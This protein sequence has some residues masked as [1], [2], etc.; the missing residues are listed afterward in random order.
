[1][2][3]VTDSPQET[4]QKEV[5]AYDPKCWIT[6]CGYGADT[7]IGWT[8]GML[9]TGLYGSL[10]CSDS[11]RSL[12]ISDQILRIRTFLADQY[13]FLT[14]QNDRK[15]STVQERLKWPT[16]SKDPIPRVK[17]AW[18]RPRKSIRACLVD[19]CPDDTDEWKRWNIRTWTNPN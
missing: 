7:S 16:E 2:G 12:R 8:K 6:P 19:Q 5:E 4:N 15:N 3:L 1:M 9:L 11:Y 10:R 17:M 14:I 13:Q 18:L